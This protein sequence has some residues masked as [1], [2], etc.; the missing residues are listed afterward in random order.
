M[1]NQIFKILLANTEF[2]IE[3]ILYNLLWVRYPMLATVC[4]EILLI[5]CSTVK[6]DLSLSEKPMAFCP[7]SCFWTPLDMISNVFVTVL[8]RG[9]H[10]IF[11]LFI[12]LVNSHQ[13]LG[14]DKSIKIVAYT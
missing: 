8:F 12:N 5:P 4:N 11:E 6:E 1:L 10:E 7:H 9:F 2:D 13:K 14:L 3:L